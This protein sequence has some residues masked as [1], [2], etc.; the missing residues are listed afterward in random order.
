MVTVTTSNGKHLGADGK[1]YP[2]TQAM[3]HEPRGEVEVRGNQ[4]AVSAA[5]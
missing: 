1:L 3:R 4:A 2:V 5:L